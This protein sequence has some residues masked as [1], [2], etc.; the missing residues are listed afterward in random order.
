MTRLCG[1]DTCLNGGRCIPMNN[2]I[3]CA[4]KSNYY[5][6]KCEF[7]LNSVVQSAS[8]S[9]DGS[10]ASRDSCLTNVC[11]NNGSCSIKRGKGNIYFISQPC[12]K[13]RIELLYLNMNYFLV[14]CVCDSHFTGKFCESPVYVPCGKGA[15]N[16]LNVSRSHLF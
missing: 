7:K 1:R 6:P 5:G 12:E 9:S 4:C 14:T 2:S 10:S 16:N 15:C 3:I 13:N 11:L 8:T